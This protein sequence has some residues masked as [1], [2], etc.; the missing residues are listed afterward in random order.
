MITLNSLLISLLTLLIFGTFILQLLHV[1]KLAEAK[2]YSNV[3]DHPQHPF[4]FTLINDESMVAW[5]MS[6]N[7]FNKEKTCLESMFLDIA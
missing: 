3:M 7:H 4:T 6:Q 5:N 2:Q 1:S